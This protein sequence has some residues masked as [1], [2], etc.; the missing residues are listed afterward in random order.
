[1]KEQ[2][3]QVIHVELLRLIRDKA[4]PQTVDGKIAE[5][6]SKLDEA[7]VVVPEFPRAAL[8]IIIAA[9]GAAIVGRL[10]LHTR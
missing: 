2:T 7:I 1:M 8:V 6:N 4:D 5:I 9:I 3:L 10:R